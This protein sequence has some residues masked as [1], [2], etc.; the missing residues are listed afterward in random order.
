MIAGKWETMLSTLVLSALHPKRALARTIKGLPLR[1]LI[2]FDSLRR[3][4]F[5]KGVTHVIDGGAHEGVFSR[6]AAFALRECLIY[7]FEPTPRTFERLLSNT[8]SI[9]RI[10]CFPVALGAADGT[11]TLRT[12]GLDQANSLLPM[13]DRHT[14]AWSGSQ[15]GASVEV[16][17]RTL[18]GILAEENQNGVF[19]VKL[20]VQG[21]ELHVL[22]GAAETLRR[23]KV[24][25][26]EA[27]FVPLYEC[28]PSFADLWMFVERSGFVFLAM[29]DLIVPPADV[30]PV[31]ANLVFVRR[32][33]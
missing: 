21:F 17:V 27:S 1:D 12:S 9:K 30:V 28:A 14:Q 24:L 26:L 4:G 5:L 29:A 31:Q 32:S 15:Q 23:T 19:L 16:C 13:T 33:Q 3:Y 25:I 2:L 6:T 20:D 7:A 8:A 10:R 18:D 11:A 22:K